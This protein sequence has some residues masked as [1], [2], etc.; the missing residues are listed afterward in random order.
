M[1]RRNLTLV[2]DLITQKG[3]PTRGFIIFASLNLHT[4]VPF[5]WYHRMHDVKEYCLLVTLLQ[6]NDWYSH[7]IN[8][9]LYDYRKL[10]V[11]KPFGKI[12]PQNRQIEPDF[13]LGITT[14]GTCKTLPLLPRGRSFREG[15][16]FLFL[17]FSPFM[18]DNKTLAERVLPKGTFPPSDS[19]HSHV[20]HSKG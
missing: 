13:S 6:K 19:N 1:Y 17:I 14:G 3:I 20:T 10:T 12:P 7:L 11:T 4:F 18:Y 15:C 2:P 5:R 9:L 8:N 16:Q